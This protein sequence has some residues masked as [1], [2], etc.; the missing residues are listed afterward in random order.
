MNDHET[1]L[2]TSCKK[3]SILRLST[4]KFCLVIFKEKKYA[5]YF[6]TKNSPSFIE[7][8]ICFDQFRYVYTN[9]KELELTSE[10]YPCEISWKNHHLSKS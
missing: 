3:D 6:F 8:L 4:N 9:Q 5:K 1:Q 2:P 10:L 7:K